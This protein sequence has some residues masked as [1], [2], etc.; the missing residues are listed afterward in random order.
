[1]TEKATPEVVEL[2]GGDVIIH[3]HR[4]S[5]RYYVARRNGEDLPKKLMPSSVTSITGL[6]DKSRALIPWATRVFTEKVQELMGDNPDAVFNR[7][8][9]EAM[10]VTGQGAHNDIKEKSAGIGDYIHEFCD[11]YSKD[12]DKEQAYSRVIEVL[13][14]PIDEDQVKIKAGIE[15]F[16]KWVISEKV[17]ILSAEQIVYSQK[18]DY[19]GKYD[20]IIEYNGKKYLTDYK[21]G[22]GI[23]NEHYYQASAYLKAYEEQT[24]EKLDGALIIAIVKEDKADKEGNVIKRAGDIIPEFRSRGDLL[25]DYI[26]FKGL[27]PVKAREKELARQWRANNK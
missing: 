26:A 27:L 11:Q 8:D 21:T 7:Q 20:A 16:V 13:G 6:I 25:Q 14:A 9:V 19:V 23:Y 24:G 4:K 12:R 18:Y 22:N 5:H 15:G 10:L 1:M 3:F 17:N 2:Y